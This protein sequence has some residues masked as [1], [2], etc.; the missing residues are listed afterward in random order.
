MNFKV[1]DEE[2]S[3]NFALIHYGSDEFRKEKFWEIRNS[4]LMVKPTGGLWTS[5]VSSEWGW[6]DWCKSEHFRECDEKNSFTVHLKPGSK[7]LVIDSKKDL[8][9]VLETHS[10]PT[11]SLTGIPKEFSKSRSP[12]FEKLLEDGCSAI[13]LTEKGQRETRFSYPS[14][15]Y[16][17]DVETV[18]ILDKNSVLWQE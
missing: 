18:L 7:L 5:P 13:W 16:G 14:T 17:W 9:S 8:Y 1:V 3:R 2:F 6:K 12:D 11:F 10:L 15:L 4:D